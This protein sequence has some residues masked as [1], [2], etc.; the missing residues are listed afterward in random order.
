MKLVFA[1][2]TGGAVVFVATAAAVD[3]TAGDAVA[4]VAIFIVVLTANTVK[5]ED[6]DRVTMHRVP[7]LGYLQILN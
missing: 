7:V 2:E 4:V 6:S 1:V 3:V 5:L